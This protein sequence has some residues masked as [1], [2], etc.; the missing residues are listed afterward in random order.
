LSPPSS[1]NFDII[2][3]GAGPA[4]TACALALKDAGLKVAVFDKHQFPR[5]KVCGDAIPSRVPKVLRGIAPEIA[6]EIKAF[7]KKVNIRGCRVVAPNLKQ[8]D[9]F[10]TLDGYISTRVDFDNKMVELMKQFSKTGFYEGNAVADVVITNDHVKIQTNKNILFNAKLVVGCDGA[11]SIVEKK[12]TSTKMDPKHYTGAVRAY[13]KNI[14]GTEDDMME[15][16]LLKEYPAAYFWIFPLQNKMA[17]VGFGMLSQKISEKKVNLRK[18]LLDIIMKHPAL[19]KRF[20]NAEALDEV[21]GYGLPMGSRRVKISGQRFMLCGDAASLIDPATGEGIGN[22]ML[23]G[24]LAAEQAVKC[25]E[26]N[27][28]SANFMKMYDESLFRVIG[29]EL[30]QKYLIQRTLGER[31][32]LANA[33]VTFA[34]KNKFVKRWLQKMF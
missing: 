30:K 26:K 2:I 1:N 23:S 8:I 21:T 5:D 16:H 20:Q 32:W 18:S 24:K 14:A 10:F 34:S 28:F 19:S 33:A 25:F 15:I 29:K 7:E 13:Y 22:A 3:V 17:N 9:I 4:G 31:A 6:D 27:N 12:I 11:H